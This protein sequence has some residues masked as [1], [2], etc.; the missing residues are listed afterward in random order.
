MSDTSF[1]S[2]VCVFEHYLERIAHLM[3][4]ATPEEL[5]GRLTP[6]SFTALENFAIAQGYVLRSLF[7][8]LG[9]EG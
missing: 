9:R 3:A 1:H 5:E 2:Y 8:L 6:E 4:Q 7:P